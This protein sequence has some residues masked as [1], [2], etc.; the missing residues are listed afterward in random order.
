[1]LSPSFPS[2]TSLRHPNPLRATDPPVCSVQGMGP[3]WELSCKTIPSSCQGTTARIPGPQRQCQPQAGCE[4]HVM[5]INTEIH[6][7]HTLNVHKE[8]QLP[9]PGR[10]RRYVTPTARTSTR[11]RWRLLLQEIR[12]FLGACPEEGGVGSSSKLLLTPNSAPGIFHLSPA[13]LSLG[14]TPCWRSS[15]GLGRV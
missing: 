3:S 11:S 13:W 9:Q 7:Q 6:P 15:Q 2:H 5:Y 14:L 10:H 8:L 1:M 12:S 4:S